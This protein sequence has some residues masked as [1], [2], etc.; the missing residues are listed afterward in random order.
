[1]TFREAVAQRVLV[2]DGAMGTQ[3]Q[4]QQLSPADFGGRE[5]AND[6]LSLTRPDLVEEIHARYLAAGCDVVETNTFGSSRLKLDDYGLGHRTYEVNFKAAIVARRAADRFSAPGRP[7]FVAGSIGPTGMLPSSSDPALSNVTP[8]AL[9]RIFLEQARGLVDGG[10]DAIIVETQQDVL[11]MRAAILA[12]EADRLRGEGGTAVLVAVDG[13][14][15]GL[16]Q[17]VDPPRP[18]AAEAVRALRAEGVRVVMVTGDSRTTAL[19]VARAVGIDEVEAEV[20]PAQKAEAVARHRAQGQKVAF[21]GDGIN[22]APALRA[23]YVSMAPATATD[24]G[25]SAAD[26]VFTGG[27]LSAVPF[28]LVVARR[29]DPSAARAVARYL[30][31]PPVVLQARAADPAE[32][33]LIIGSD[34]SRVRM[35][36]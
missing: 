9:E 29:E 15:A 28:S 21:A 31:H 24:I 17:V 26:F 8:D 4:R 34:R 20:L 2:F 30:G 22:D 11:E 14:P 12:A 35:E 7:R 23:A 1:V 10:V 25:R 36:P 19:A 27:Q 5:G 16:L 18:A 33:T 3:I 32:V 13:H 6:L